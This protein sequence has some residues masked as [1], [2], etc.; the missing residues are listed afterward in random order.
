[1]SSWALAR[2]S[3]RNRLLLAL[4]ATI[5]A[6][7]SIWLAVLSSQ[8]SRQ[9]TGVWDST[10]RSVATQ[11]VLSMP[12]DVDRLGAPGGLS[13]PSTASFEGDK[14]SFQIWTGQPRRLVLSSPGAGSTPLAP[15]ALLRADVQAERYVDQEVAGQRW[16]VYVLTD[17]QARVLVQVG[18]QSA[19]YQADQL[20]WLA[21]STATAGLL[22]LALAAAV[23]AV[24]RWSM[25]PVQKLQHRID[26]RAAGS[27]EP[28]IEER[29]PE[30]LR[31]LLGSFN[32]LLRRVDA[33][34]QTE[35]S[36]IADAAHEL[37]TPLSALLLQAEVAQRTHSKGDVT[38]TTEAL[39][40]L[41][42][43]ALRGA[44]LSEQLLDS[45]RL[46][47]G[48]ATQSA[49][50]VGLHHLVPLIARDFQAAA[51]RRQQTIK[52]VVHPATVQ[53]HVD[54]L[55]ILIRNLIDNALR[56]SPPASRVTVSCD[57]VVGVA[58]PQARLCV[59]DEGPG[60]PSDQHSQLPQRFRRGGHR[61]ERGSG[62]GL[63]LVARAVTLHRASLQFGPGLN[64]HGLTVVVLFA[65]AMAEPRVDCGCTDQP[66]QRRS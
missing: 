65:S 27:T 14:I 11:L 4:L 60:L 22:F 40:H 66:D 45:A 1:M 53:G 46:E 34:I 28:L 12:A 59:S 18:R 61:R 55:G 48:G 39:Q 31:P 56:Y 10:L 54:E 24:V 36:F 30:E 32:V 62:I 5:F 33:A 17:T 3:L 37:R 41:H 57:E 35:R 15:A 16:R 21:A 47:A 42:D 13:L 29:L 38:G 6:V 52:L 43:V 20:R 19:Q 51:E 8:M 50:P 7:W 23:W 58:P 64:G 2:V 49:K 26:Q 25:A 9:Q 63:S 44:R